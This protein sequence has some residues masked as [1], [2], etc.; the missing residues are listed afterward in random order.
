MFCAKSKGQSTLEY[1]ILLGFIV[2]ALIAMGIYMKRGIQGRLR[3]ST[4]QVGEQYSARNTKSSYT[5]TTGTTQ[6]ENM[7]SGGRT[8]TNIDRNIQT[9]TG[10][11]TVSKL[12]DEEN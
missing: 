3:E 11:E 5:V 2:A 1:V 10:D 12:A 8:T 7:E 4:D 9:K 6:I